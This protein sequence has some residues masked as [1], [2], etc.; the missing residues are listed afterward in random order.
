MRISIFTS[1]G[2]LLTRWGSK[3]INKKEELFVAPHDVAIDSKGDLYVGEVAKSFGKVDK[4]TK[5]L[6]KFV[7][8]YR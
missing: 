4:G 8:L 2:E 6:H 3:G 1:G 7:R 5:A